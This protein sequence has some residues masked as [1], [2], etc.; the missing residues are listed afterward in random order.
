MLLLEDNSLK[1]IIKLKWIILKIY[2]IVSL[3]TYVIKLELEPTVFALHLSSDIIIKIV[4]S[5]CFH[6]SKCN[7]SACS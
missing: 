1:I 4:F 6:L 2:K 5:D 3:V 7:P